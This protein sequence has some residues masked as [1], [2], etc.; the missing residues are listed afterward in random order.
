MSDHPDTS[1]ANNAR[2]DDG[3]QNHDANGGENS[4][5]AGVNGASSASA[6]DQAKSTMQPFIAQFGDGELD[7]PSLLAMA[8]EIA[9]SCKVRKN[10]FAKWVRQEIDKL[11]HK[12][13]RPPPAPDPGGVPDNPEVCAAERDAAWSV[14]KDLAQAPDLIARLL[15]AGLRLGIAGDRRGILG[16]SLVMVSRLLS[17]P[18]RMLRKGAAASGKSFV[19]DKLV[20]LLNDYD[21]IR[22]TA[23]SARALFYSPKIFCHR[24]V[25]IGEATALVPGKDGDQAFEGALRELIS[26]G[27]IVYDTVERDGESGRLI[28]V[29]IEKVGPIALVTTVAREIVEEELGTR[30]LVELADESQQQTRVVIDAATARLAGKAPPPLTEVELAQWRALQDWLRLGS[31]E[32]VI[33]FAPALGRLVA[34][35]QLRVRR[36]ISG[37]LALV[38]AS[39]LLHRAQRQVDDAGRIVADIRDY[40]IAVAALGAGLDEIQH[41]DI[42]KL[43]QVRQVVAKELCEEQR[44]FRRENTVREFVKEL[45]RYCGQYNLTAATQRIRDAQQSRR[46]RQQLATAAGCVAV[47]TNNGQDPSV[48]TTAT[49]ARLDRL[50]RRLLRQAGRKAG[51]RANEPTSVEVS[52]QTLAHH[53]GIGHKAAR[54]RLQNAIEAGAVVDESQPHRARTAPRQLA[55]GKVVA[56]VPRR[57][58]RGAFPDADQVKEA[59]SQG[60]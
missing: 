14:C 25:Y 17:D 28:G 46:G 52:Y 11:K 4:T 8:D 2:R 33:P 18:A 34:V 58:R 19:I 43:E 50:C 26:N 30:L 5:G 15:E 48:G 51:Q 49:P 55:P 29:T 57:Q 38:Q 13:R 40:K 45:A 60:A 16:V 59:W 6:F 44:R 54:V 22:I 35:D 36:D 9:A 21:Y 37:V 23:A 31:R 39:A 32:V 10:Y 1:T 53:L 42:T 56:N 41:G 47:A 12:Q 24:F 7:E 3:V 27:R 20:Q